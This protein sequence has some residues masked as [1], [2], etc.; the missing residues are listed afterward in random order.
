L[1]T[2]RH[3]RSIRAQSHFTCIFIFKKSHWLKKI[4]KK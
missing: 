1:S 3:K 4:M 2:N